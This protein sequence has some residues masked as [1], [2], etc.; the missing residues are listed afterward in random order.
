MMTHDNSMLKSAR[1]KENF[2]RPGLLLMLAEVILFSLLA[3]FSS[4]HF[5]IADGAKITAAYLV[6]Y[7][8]PRTVL[9]R[10]SAWSWGSSAVLLLLS[11]L[12]IYIDYK[13]LLALTLFDGYSLEMPNL[14]GDAR[15]YY[16]WALGQYD[17]R[18]ETAHMLFPGFPYIMVGLWKIFGVSIVW[19]QAMNLMFT[20]TSV[21]FTGKFT[22]RLLSNRVSVAPRHLLTLGL[23]FSCFLTYYLIVGTLILKEGS[24]FLGLAMAAYALSSL[25]TVDGTHRLSRGDMVLFVMA[26]LLVTFIR[27]TFLYFIAMG[28]IVMTLLHLKRDWRVMSV[29]LAIVVVALLL[30][31]LLSQYTFSRHAE[32]AGGGWNMQR[33]YVVGESQQFYHDLLNYYFLYSFWHKVLMLPLTMSV[34]FFIPLPWSYFD[35]PTTINIIGRFSYCWYFVGGTALFYYFF[36]SWRKGE[37]MGLWP[38]WPALAYAAMAYLMAGSVARYVSPILPLFIPVTVYVLCRVY[39]GHRRKSFIWW[40]ITLVIVITLVLLLCLEIQQGTISKMLH[41]QSLVH[42]WKGLPY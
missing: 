11:V 5:G 38:W 4:R 3:V 13:R 40:W 36:L 1:L 26:S 15:S 34:Q 7:L 31:E 16:K 10:D 20:M 12:L 35:T 33:F 41:T 28:V 18:F 27:P 29:L 25:A 9:R 32:I 14:S 19:P 17:G 6:A 21:V 39:E 22:R 2:T 42:Y 37:H 8:V 23:F 30:G 24:I